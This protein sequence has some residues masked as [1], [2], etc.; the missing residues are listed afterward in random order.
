[1][2]RRGRFGAFKTPALRL[3]REH[4]QLL[5]DTAATTTSSSPTPWVIRRSTAARSRRTS[6]AQTPEDEEIALHVV[7]ETDEGV[8]VSGGK[9]LSTAAVYSNEML[10][11]AVADVLRPQRPALRPGVLDSD[12]NTPGLKIL[13]REP[14]GRWFG[15]WGHPFQTWTS[16]TAC[17]SSTACSCRGTASSSCTSRRRA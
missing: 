13:A 17:C 5:P 6:G 12:C 4:R 16:R 1:M 7:E 2:P 11:L 8:I 9:Q 15:S 14:V 10:R 3:R